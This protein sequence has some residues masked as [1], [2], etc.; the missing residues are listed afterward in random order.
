MA[1]NGNKNGRGV[2]TA[3]RPEPVCL[4]SVKEVAQQCHLSEKTIRRHIESGRLRIQRVGRAIR[5][6]HAEL[7]IFLGLP[8][9]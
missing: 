3:E 9:Q 1:P 4:Y 6:P 8:A 2:R 5:I 7:L